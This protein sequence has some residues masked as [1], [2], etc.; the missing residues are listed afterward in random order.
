M[1]T[2]GFDVARHVV[3]GVAVMAGLSGSALAQDKPA[4][5]EAANAMIGAWEFSNA[6]RDKICRF[7]FRS[8]TVTGGYKLD[9][10]RNC[11]GIFPTTKDIVGWTVDNFGGLHLL[12]AGGTAVID[13]SEAEVGLYDGFEPEQGRYVLQSAAAVPVRSAEELIGDWA[14]ARGTGKPLCILTL[15]NN[16]A[17]TDALMLKVKPGCDTMVTRFAPNSWRMEQSELVL[18]SARG[19]TWRFEENDANTWQRVPESS[20]PVLLVRQ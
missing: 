17:G 10:D 13:L 5:S 15:A 16:P 7:N 18:L 4:M 14:I 11:A 12:N 9:I 20:D 1:I 6:D 19:Q 8:E 2:P 3:F